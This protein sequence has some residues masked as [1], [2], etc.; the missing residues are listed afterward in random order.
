MQFDYDMALA[1]KLLSQYWLTIRI[2]ALKI[3]LIQARFIQMRR[4]CPMKMPR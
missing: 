1:D 3:S 2:L 4:N